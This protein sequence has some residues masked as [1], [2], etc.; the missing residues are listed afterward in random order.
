MINDLYTRGQVFWALSNY[1]KLDLDAKSDL[2]RAIQSELI[3]GEM[4]QIIY[5]KFNTELLVMDCLELLHMEYDYFSEVED[6]MLETLEAIM[7]GYPTKRRKY[8]VAGQSLDEM[9]ELLGKCEIS[10]FLLSTDA[11]T[12]LL[13]WLAE[14]G[15]VLSVEVLRQRVEGMPQHIYDE[16]FNAK[17]SVELYNYYATGGQG[18]DDRLTAQYQNNGVISFAEFL[19]LALQGFGNGNSKK[20]FSEN[21]KMKDVV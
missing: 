21:K 15:D 4:L 6:E 5:L 9:L 12:D 1:R 8:K 2:D 18:A 11:I 16:L 17:Y 7:N 3:T 10:P 19:S 14:K 13:E 20:R